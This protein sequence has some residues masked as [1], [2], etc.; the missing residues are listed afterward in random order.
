MTTGRSN[1]RRK[2]IF[3]Q[4]FTNIKCFLQFA[5]S[6]DCEQS[7]LRT[8]FWMWGVVPWYLWKSPV[9]E[10]IPFHPESGSLLHL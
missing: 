1:M 2:D 7:V 5:N 6:P 10:H 9:I 4:G 8:N 3:G